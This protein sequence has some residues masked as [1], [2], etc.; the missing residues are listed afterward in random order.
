MSFERLSI[1]LFGGSFNP[2]HNG[3][4]H[5]AKTAMRALELDQIWWM[6]SPQNPLKPQ[7]PSYESRVA[8][9]EALGLPY[10]MKISHMETIFGTQYTIDTLTKAKATWPKT[11]FVF[12]MGADN[13][14]QLPKWRQWKKIMETM[15]IAVIARPGKNYA[16]IRS[17]L[18]KA[19]QIYKA[20]RLPESQA[21]ILKHCQ[22]PAW[23]YLTPPMNSQSSSAIRAQRNATDE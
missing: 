18:G 9:V 3:H 19:A 1:G 14:L 22:A 15:P 12:L 21:D 16:A 20:Y 11:N 6:V 5:V 17:R 10:A 23:S 2:A 13:L 4:M 8:T 7:Q